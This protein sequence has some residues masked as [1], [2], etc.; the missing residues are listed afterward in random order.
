[1]TVPERTLRHPPPNTR[2]GLGQAGHRSH[3]LGCTKTR[4]VRGSGEFCVDHRDGLLSGELP[5]KGLGI[6]ECNGFQIIVDVNMLT[7]IVFVAL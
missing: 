2:R 1:M 6:I 5:N 3:G 4:H 7:A